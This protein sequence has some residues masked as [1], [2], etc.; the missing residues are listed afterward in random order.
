M[1]N[2]IEI[3]FARKEALY[4]SMYTYS[5]DAVKYVKEKPLKNYEGPKGIDIIL[6]DI[7]KG[8]NTNDYT[9]KKAQSVVHTL[10]N[11]YG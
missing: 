10:I 7:D 1:D 9:L 11:D 8:T 4:R 2:K 6:L 3:A 5:D